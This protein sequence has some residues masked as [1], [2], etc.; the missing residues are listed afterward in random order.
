MTQNGIFM[1]QKMKLN[2]FVQRI[3]PLRKTD[4]MYVAAKYAKDTYAI[5]D[6]TLQK[7]ERKLSSM[8]FT[9]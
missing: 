2:F 1:T 7:G 3:Y 4:L 9:E 5:I 8:L 6:T